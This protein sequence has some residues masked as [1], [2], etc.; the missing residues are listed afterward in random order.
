MNDLV[1][2]P[3]Y[4]P[5]PIQIGALSPDFEARSTQ[6]PFRL[7]NL[8]GRWVLFFSHPAD[9]TP[10]C[11]SEFVALQ[12]ASGEFAA[13]GCELV[14]LSVDSV[15]SHLA[16][17]RDIE[18]RFGVEITFPIVEDISM[19][20]A[21]AYGMIHAAS[22]STVSVRSV[23]FIDPDRI[24]RAMIQYPMNV[25]RSV[26]ELLRVL[27]ALR[28]ADERQVTTPEGWRPGKPTVL[29]PPE[30]LADIAERTSANGANRAWYYT[31]MKGED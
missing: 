18:A 28:E 19:A 2:P 21:S 9:F 29:P 3:S 17:I 23:F 20:V 8:A 12:R 11:T 15:Y 16:W 4:A 7:S 10:V 22:T 26:D 31:E 1:E 25:G 14:G 27:A 5:P 6:G 24:I 13:L 30:T